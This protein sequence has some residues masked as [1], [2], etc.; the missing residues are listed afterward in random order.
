MVGVLLVQALLCIELLLVLLL[1][2]VGMCVL[3]RCRPL[4]LGLL[5]APSRR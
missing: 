3:L 1:Y 2:D 4:A 5:V